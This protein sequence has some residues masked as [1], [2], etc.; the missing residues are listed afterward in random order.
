MKLS[1]N[2]IKLNVWSLLLLV[3][4]AGVG[5]AQTVEPQPGKE[6]E[7]LLTL[8]VTNSF[9]S[10][11]KGLKPE[12]F[13]ISGDKQPLSISSFSDRDE[14]ASIAFLVDTSGSMAVGNSNDNKLRFFISSI[15]NFQI[16]ANEA[17]EYAM[18]S[19]SNEANLA[20]DWTQDKRAIEQSL[21]EIAAKPVKGQTAFFDACRQG[22]DLMSRSKYRKRVIIL[23]TDGHDNVS[24]DARF[25]KLKEQVRA[26]DTIFYSV[27]FVGQT[28]D[29]AGQ[30]QLE[31]LAKLTGGVALYPK[32][33]FDVAA[34]F[35]VIGRLLRN[36]YVVGFKAAESADKKW[37]PVKVEIKLPPDAP[38]E[39]KY[40]V[41]RHR[42]GYFN[43]L[44]EP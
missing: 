24:K 12:H 23:L 31:E 1:P 4:L 21:A 16:E 22:L 5:L 6:R 10:P 34:S 2:R 38:R 3:V 33:Q 43:R 19:F 41:I 44:G 18:L 17:N 26:N 42:A 20:Q 25:G 28:L 37:H 7:I 9:G 11:I 27:S 29:V 13:K 40:P 30:D 15:M 35:E 32:G 39:L 8:T 36:Q 14:P